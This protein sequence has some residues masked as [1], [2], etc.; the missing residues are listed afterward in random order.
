MAKQHL[1]RAVRRQVN[2]A[3]KV[4]KEHGL[5]YDGS[6]ALASGTV[7][8]PEVDPEKAEIDP[9]LKVIEGG[10]DPDAAPDPN[11][12]ANPDG[13]DDDDLDLDGDDGDENDDPPPTAAQAPDPIAVMQQQHAAAMTQLRNEMAQTNAQLQ[14]VL[15]KYNTAQ[16]QIAQLQDA[17]Q[18]PTADPDPEPIRHT[19][20]SREEIDDYGEDMV[21]MVQ[22]AAREVFQPELDKLRREN[23]ELVKRVGE[24]GKTTETVAQV[25]TA[26]TVEGLLTSNL[27]EWR[28]INRDPEFL[29]WLSEV[30]PLMNVKK[31]DALKHA[32]ANGDANRVLAFFQG[33]L[34]SRPQPQPEPEPDPAPQVTLTELA[35]PTPSVGAPSS[36]TQEEAKI[37]TRK[38][39]SDFYKEVTGGKYRADPA[40]Q[41]AIERD[42]LKA[43]IEGRIQ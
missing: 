23:A 43:N 15:G 7:P 11:D 30:D 24:V 41:R 31:H 16:Q 6:T 5:D 17:T 37:W 34:A 19:L 21:G 13:G 20:L 18:P 8:T 9:P 32:Y 10:A 27:P 4:A 39:I 28:K 40:R 36:G 1:P 14:D 29:S 22:K 25:Q 3:R 12:N 33:F 35:A 42:I 2:R 26:N 38:E